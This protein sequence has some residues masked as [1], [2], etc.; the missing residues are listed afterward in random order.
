MPQD[1]LDEVT[2]LV[3]WPMALRGSFDK[4]FLKIPSLALISTMKNHQKYFHLTNRA[5][6]ELLPAFITVSN[7]ESSSP[8]VVIAGNERVIRPRLS[9][10]AF[11]FNND[12]KSSLASKRPLLAGVVFQNK[13]GT[14]LDKTN[15]VAALAKELSIRMGANSKIVVRAAELSKCDLVSEMVLEFPEMQG[16]AGAHYA[17]HDGEPEEVANAIQSH[18]KPR[19]AGDSL[20]STPEATALALAAPC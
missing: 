19:F 9:D 6:G 3:E 1:L 11:F 12:K 13:L 18:Y 15:R 2:G 5:S 16:I 8:S 17:R 10:A 4:E 14:L 20:P 7:I